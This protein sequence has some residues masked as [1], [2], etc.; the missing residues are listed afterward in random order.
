M[1]YRQF[2]HKAYSTTGMHE[3]CW[4]DVHRPLTRRGRG[5]SSVAVAPLQCMCARAQVPPAVKYGLQRVGQTGR[6][7]GIVVQ[8]LLE[9][10]L[11]R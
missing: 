8:P 11:S 10:C 4:I 9:C 2:V 5:A 1:G 7:R 3:L 6:G